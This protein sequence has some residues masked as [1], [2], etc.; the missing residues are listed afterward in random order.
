MATD[1]ILD[2][3]FYFDGLENQELLIQRC[4]NC[5]AVRYP[6]IPICSQCKSRE[7]G[8]FAVKGDGTLRSY[9]IMRRPQ[10]PDLASNIA[11]IVDLDEGVSIASSLVG[12][13]PEDVTFDMRVR[14][15]F[16]KAGGYPIHVFRPVDNRAV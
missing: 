7:W 14:L 16:T 2:R 9:V 11:V 8:S 10:I 6:A 4:R 13:E 15:E 12:I 3:Q 1:H 5:E